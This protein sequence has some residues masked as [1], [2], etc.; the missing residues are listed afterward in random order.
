MVQ[1]PVPLSGDEFDTPEAVET[2]LAVESAVECH[3][4]F[5]SAR[6]KFGRQPGDDVEQLARATLARCCRQIFGPGSHKRLLAAFSRFRSWAYQAA[7]YTLPSI[8]LSHPRRVTKPHTRLTSLESA[9]GSYPADCQT[10][11]CARG[12]ER[13]LAGRI[14]C[15]LAATGRSKHPE[16]GRST[17]SLTGRAFRASGK[18][19]AGHGNTRKH[20][21]LSPASAQAKC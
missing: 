19:C 1:D 2:E 6:M 11:G 13:P 17:L 4:R 14:A 9:I 8:G 15:P 10:R 16:S 5:R 18:H 7:K 20:G 21:A 12:K 3:R